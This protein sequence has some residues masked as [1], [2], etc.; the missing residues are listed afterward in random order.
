[1]T[2]ILEW[3]IICMSKALETSVPGFGYQ[4]SNAPLTDDQP[5]ASKLLH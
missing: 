5:F 2:Y 3:G 4:D 1:M